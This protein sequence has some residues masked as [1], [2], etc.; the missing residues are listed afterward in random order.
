VSQTVMEEKPMVEDHGRA[1][2]VPKGDKKK[3][4]E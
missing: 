4:R 1:D 2:F 3:V